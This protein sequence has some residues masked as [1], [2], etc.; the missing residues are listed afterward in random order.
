MIQLK[1]YFKDGHVKIE[2]ES[3]FENASADLLNHYILYEGHEDQILR[4]EIA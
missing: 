1:I 4:V 3:S 2:D